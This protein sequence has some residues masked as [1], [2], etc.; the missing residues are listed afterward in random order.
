MTKNQTMSCAD[1]LAVHKTQQAVNLIDQKIASIICS[2][3]QNKF[4]SENKV[5]FYIP[6]RKLYLKLIGNTKLRIFDN[7]P[8]HLFVKKDK[9][10]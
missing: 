10:I 7:G 8:I 1:V 4:V 6:V 9:N 5:V 3:M 2:P